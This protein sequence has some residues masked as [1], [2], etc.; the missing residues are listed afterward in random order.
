MSALKFP[1]RVV[2][3]AGSAQWAGGETFLRQMAEKLDRTRFEMRVICPEEGPLRREMLLREV[4]CEVVS[5]A[6]LGAPRPAFALRKRLAE[7]EADVI[8]S[9]GARSN[10]YAR[11]A[12]GRIP[13]VS[14]IHNALSDYPV[15]L[16]RKSLY[17]LMD[18]V[19]VFRSNRVV[20]VS[21]ALREEFLGRAP[22]L[23]DR[24]FVIHNGVDLARFNPALYNRNKIRAELKLHSLWTL[25]VVGRM[26][27]Q[28]GHVH[29]LR[30][31]AMVKRALPP[32]RLLLIG[33]GPL[34]GS[35]EREAAALGLGEVCRFLGVRRDIPELLAAIDVALLPS[36]TEGFPYALLESLAM[37]KP[38]LVT[39]IGGVAEAM[40]TGQEAFAVPPASPEKIAEAILTILWNPDEARERAR[41]GRE[42]VTKQYDAVRWIQAWQEF[43][44]SLAMGGP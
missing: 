42:R 22:G 27:E 5:L 30:A 32:F 14:T 36:L 19:S 17:M 38:T 37:G 43:Y 23:W 1:I 16:W 28:K 4:P 26:T 7:W 44:L 11:L 6:P 40:P 39:S 21:E 25:G 10:F 34:R 9:H 13:L 24:T 15:P 31:L 29:L 41:K 3:V 12:S 2:H 35:L 20:C 33:D 18:R 8:Q